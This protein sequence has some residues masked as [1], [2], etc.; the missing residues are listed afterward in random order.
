MNCEDRIEA[1]FRGELVDQVPFV[2]K[3]WRIPPCR[4]ERELRNDG[5]GIVDS[6]GVYSTRSPNTSTEVLQYSENGVGYIRTTVRTPEG[7][8]TSVRR[9]MGSER[10]ESTSWAVEPMF[11]GPE[12]Y[13]RLTAMVRDREYAPAY[14][15]YLKAQAQMD[16]EAFF[17]TG[18]P[19]APIHII[20]YQYLGIEQFSIEWAER[21]DEVLAL[22]DAMT[23]N[24]RPIY[25]I[26]A[27]SPALVVQCGG[28]YASEVLGKERFVDHVLPHWEEVGEVLHKGGKLLGCHLDANNRLWAEEVGQSKLDWIEAFSPAPDTDMTVAEGRELWPGK[29][30]FINFPSAVHLETP[31]GIEAATKQMLKESAPGDRFII[32]IT[33]NVPENRW[34]ESFDTILKTVN[35]FGKLPIQAEALEAQA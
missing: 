9:P 12:D 27:E 22:A 13:A 5:M 6:R 24:Q 7:E 18:A 35:R 14:G 21:R 10:I 17:K 28:N 1:I 29:V 8:L 31:A 26:V 20:M 34:R 16:G 4:M 25:P 19:G 2:L 30:L 3:G 11:K 33:E 32:G 23:E 15:G